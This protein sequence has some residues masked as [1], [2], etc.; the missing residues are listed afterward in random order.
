LTISADT[1]L[2]FALAT[3][4]GTGEI[5]LQAR[6]RDSIVEIGRNCAFS[7]NVSLIAMNQITIGDDCLVGDMVSII[8]CDFHDIHPKRRRLSAGSVSPVVIGSNVW[9]GSRVMVMKGVTI[10]E[11]SVIAAA[12]VVTRS[13]PPNSLAAGIPAR[14]IRGI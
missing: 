13:I 11:N 1:T 9:L 8:D 4:L 7:N 6:G 2:G 3:K 14:V 12:G 10:G 5:L